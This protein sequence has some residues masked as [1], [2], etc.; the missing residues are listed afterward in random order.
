MKNLKRHSERHHGSRS[1][2]EKNCRQV[3]CSRVVEVT[4]DDTDSGVTFETMEF[5]VDTETVDEAVATILENHHMFT[6]QAMM[7]ILQEHFPEVPSAARHL[8]VTVATS[9]ARYVA[10]IEEIHRTAGTHTARKAAGSLMSWRH[11]LRRA[12]VPQAAKSSGRSELLVLPPPPAFAVQSL[13]PDPS[14]TKGDTL[15]PDPPATKGDIL[16][17][18]DPPTVEGDILLQSLREAGLPVLA[19]PDPELEAMIDEELGQQLVVGDLSDGNTLHYADLD[20]RDVTG[21][22]HDAVESELLY[23]R[24]D[25]ECPDPSVSST[26]SQEWEK[27]LISNL[28]TTSSPG[29]VSINYVDRSQLANH[30]T[31]SK[32][33]EKKYESCCQLWL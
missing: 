32:E 9:A 3:S 21:F 19:L 11:G 26:L 22:C 13:L 27:L 24:D 5:R 8:F 10:G 1:T 33:S 12:M 7:N 6:R 25:T 31:T 14:A 2:D 29:P 4:A 20:G 17:H 15:L 16:Q 23:V 18:P 30:Y 28:A